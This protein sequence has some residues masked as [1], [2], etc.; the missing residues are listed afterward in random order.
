MYGTSR[1]G[2][3]GRSVRPVAAGSLTALAV[4]TLTFAS[5]G[6]LLPLLDRG[7][8]RVT[9]LHL[10]VALAAL[11]V[12]HALAGVWSPARGRVP[13]WRLSDATA[14]VAVGALVG[15]AA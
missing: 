2:V 11:A 13:E 3:V 14:S 10:A 7:L 5:R 8:A 15:A 9:L 6:V 12:V 1:I 4:G